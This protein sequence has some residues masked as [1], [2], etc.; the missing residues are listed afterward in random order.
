MSKKT[1]KP[2]DNKYDHLGL[3]RLIFFSDA[4]FAIAITLLAIEIHLPT[5]DTL[6]TDAE[7]AAALWRIWPQYL[8]YVI[9]FLVIGF[10]WMSH[11]RKFGYIQRYD[12][13]LMLINLL[14]LMVIGF[15]PFP[16]SVI[17]EYG[18]Q[19]ATIFYAG[20][21]VIIGILSTILW[22]YASHRNRLISPQLD[23]SSRRRE[24]LGPLTII[25]VF[26]LSIGLAFINDDLAK[27]S[28]VLVIV[29]WLFIR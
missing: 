7:L 8:G 3:E 9:S 16:T 17:S 13:R 18:N 2:T 15:V 10:F 19:T 22:W 28:W 6:R 23:A 4:V 20:V 25:A 21:I 5:P 27:L 24:L 1:E 26:L 14:F 11:H 12:K 29:V